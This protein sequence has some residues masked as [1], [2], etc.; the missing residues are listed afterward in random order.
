MNNKEKFH[1]GNIRDFVEKNSQFFDAV[2]KLRTYAS[3]LGIRVL[4]I[5]P[6]GFWF[7]EPEE[8]LASEKLLGMEIEKINDSN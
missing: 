3:K 5:K 1:S 6:A 4:K 7:P 2:M 8:Q